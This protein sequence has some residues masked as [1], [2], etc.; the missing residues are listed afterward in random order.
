MTAITI[1]ADQ[2]RVGDLLEG[3]AD[4]E[5][6][7]IERWECTESS[8]PSVVGA[9]GLVL[10]DKRDRGYEFDLDEQIQVVRTAARSGATT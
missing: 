8:D 4:K 3:D 2:V 9:V 5:I 6:D 7:R 10:L 1:R